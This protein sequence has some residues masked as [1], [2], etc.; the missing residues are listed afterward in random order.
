[1]GDGTPEEAAGPV[2]HHQAGDRSRPGRLAGHGDVGGVA[3]ECG[4]VLLD[5][6]QGGHLVEQAP[7]VGVGDIVAGWDVAEALEAESVVEGHYDESG[8]GQCGA[9]EV[10]LGRGPK[11]VGT[12]VDPDQ[13]R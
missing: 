10:G 1:M 2:H 8:A 5:P 12:A 9:V 6:V 4:D 7:V 3:T 11:G 13:D